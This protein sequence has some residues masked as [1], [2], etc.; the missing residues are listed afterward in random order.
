MNQ[1][2]FANLIVIG[3]VVL[4]VVLGIGGYFVL[5]RKSAAPSETRQPPQGECPQGQPDCVD[6]ITNG[7]PSGGGKTVSP[8][9][10]PS[11]TPY[12]PAKLDKSDPAPPAD[13][14]LAEITVL[15][16]TDEDTSIRIDEIRDYIRYPAATNPQLKVGDIVSIRFNGW[17]DTF[18]SDDTVC[19]AGYTKNPKPAQAE[20]KEKSP[21][22]P[23]PQPKI[24]V[25]TKGSS[26]LFG[27]FAKLNCQTIGWSGWLY[28][29]SPRV[30]EYEC[31][32][33]GTTP[34][35]VVPQSSSPAVEP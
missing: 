32:K 6:Y 28:N 19:S 17:L 12:S 16:Q 14:A 27:C 7:A 29:P 5:V 13:Q 22:I 25:G 23:R 31:V 1:K 34:P 2:G 18:R 30:M 8:S 26:K 20:S 35:S 33:Q 10:A 4:V 9:K 15:S 11:P 21:G 3:I 24:A